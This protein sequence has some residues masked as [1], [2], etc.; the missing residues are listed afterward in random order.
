MGRDSP[1]LQKFLLDMHGDKFQTLFGAD[2]GSPSEIFEDLDG[3]KERKSAD[4]EATPE[5][6][7]SLRNY[8]AKGRTIGSAEVYNSS[9]THP[10]AEDSACH[11]LPSSS[12]SEAV[13]SWSGGDASMLKYAAKSR[14]I[15][16]SEVYNQPSSGTMGSLS[17]SVQQDAQKRY[18]NKR[19]D[20]P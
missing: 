11:G 10:R 13:S 3:F 16:S 14:K 12:S 6:S 17:D 4:E 20:A 15:G 18:N 19:K 2:T 9:S 7:Q 1:C 8:A 5:V